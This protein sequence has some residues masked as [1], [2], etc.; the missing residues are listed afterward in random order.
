VPFFVETEVCAGPLTLLSIEGNYLLSD[1]QI[2]TLI[3][4][5]VPTE[6]REVYYLSSAFRPNPEGTQKVVI[7]IKVQTGG[8]NVISVWRRASDT[9]LV[10]GVNYSAK[11]TLDVTAMLA[12]GERHEFVGED[13]EIAAF[14]EALTPLMPLRATAT[15]YLSYP[16]ET[17]E[18]SFAFPVVAEGIRPGFS[19]IEG[20]EVVKRRDDAPD[21]ARL[22][23]ARVR[24]T[25]DNIAT[26][27]QIRTSITSD[28][29]VLESVR[30]GILDI[31]SLLVRPKNVGAIDQ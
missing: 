19:A 8:P 15:A 1:D 26:R 31:A 18:P 5:G 24:R 29:T 25:R 13:A 14:L 22:Y 20:V 3:P 9:I 4:G 23:D 7:R 30:P 27:I 6:S 17:N 10:E 12:T 11:L 2:N 28:G 21:G 16:T